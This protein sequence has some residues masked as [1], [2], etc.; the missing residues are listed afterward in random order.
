MDPAPDPDIFAMD[1][2]DANKKISFSTY[3]FLKVPTFT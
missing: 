2:Q 3:Y 1:L